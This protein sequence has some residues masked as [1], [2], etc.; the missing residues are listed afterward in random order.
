M[1]YAYRNA[2]SCSDN[3][4]YY[5]YYFFDIQKYELSDTRLAKDQKHQPRIALYQYIYAKHC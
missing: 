4:S 1:I 2:N 3:M 5:V